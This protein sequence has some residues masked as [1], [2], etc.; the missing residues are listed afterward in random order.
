MTNLNRSEASSGVAGV[1]PEVLIQKIRAGGASIEIG[2]L[3][4]LYRNYLTLLARAQIDNRLKC[5][6]D[7]S[8]VVQETFLEAHRDFGQCRGEGE[9]ELVCWLRRIL[10]RNIMDQAKRQGAQKRDFRR[11]RSLE[12]ELNRSGERL[13]DRLN[14]SVSSPSR[15]L[16]KREQAVLLADALATLP[17]EYRDVII[18]RNIYR[19]QFQQIGDELGKSAGA[20]RM[21]WLRALERLRNAME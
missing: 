15:Q 18:Y 20:V 10:I 16:A 5:R 7:A 9:A 4:E 12:A 8:D 3:L 11:E 17:S 21:I 1:V 19:W 14:A 6:M 2:Q 13:L